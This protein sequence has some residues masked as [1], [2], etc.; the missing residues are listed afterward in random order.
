M[1][2][3][4]KTLWSCM[5]GQYV[6]TNE[7]QAS[8][9]KQAKSVVFVAAAGAM[10]VCGL[11]SAAEFQG[12]ITNQNL[13]TVT[14][15]GSTQATTKLVVGDGKTVQI[16][17]NGS[18]GKLLNRVSSAPA[19]TLD[20]IQHIL[21]PTSDLSHVVI[22]GV[23]GGSNVLNES[24]YTALSE[25]AKGSESS[26]YGTLI[27]KALASFKVPNS[28]PYVGNT[29]IY[30]GD[31]NRESNPLVIGVVGGDLAVKT[32]VKRQGSSLVQM[33]S[34][35][36]F[37]VVGGSAVVDLLNTGGEETSAQLDAAQVRVDGFANA[38]GIVTGGLAVALS[39][40]TTAS[41]VGS[42]HLIFDADPT[43]K[44][45]DLDG[46][47]AGALGGGLSVA[48]G[49][50]F[51]SANA[52]SQTTIELK[53]G[54]IVGLAGGG[55]AVA[56]DIGPEN[57]PGEAPIPQ[58]IH[59]MFFDGAGT[60][61]ALSGDVSVSLGA[62]STTLAVA[63]GGI[64][65]SDAYGS[66][67]AQTN[68]DVKSVSMTLDGNALTAEQ[69][70]QV[71]NAFYELGA[72]AGKVTLEGLQSFLG[73]VS[74]DGV[75]VGTIGGGA[76]VA[77]G[78]FDDPQS[79]SANAQSSVESVLMTVNGG[80][81][82]GVFGGGAAVGWD[83]VSGSQ[84]A[85]GQIQA[86]S[87]V[88]SSTIVVNGGENV[89]VMGG[90]LSYAT[91]T[92]GQNT[93]VAARSVVKT[94]NLLVRNGSV[95]GLVGG[96]LAWNNTN[97]SAVN[98]SVSAETVNILVEGGTVNVINTD[99]FRK[100]GEIGTEFADAFDA[101]GAA[102]VGGGI[103]L[104]EAADATVD[105]VNISVT[106][107]T[108]TGDIVAGGLVGA[109]TD[110]P[111]VSTVRNASVLLS[112]NALFEGRTID[113]STVT[114]EA[115]LFLDGEAVDLAEAT[116]KGFTAL[117]ANGA[118]SIGTV[119]LAGRQNTSFAGLFD[120]AS[121]KNE[122][123]DG[124]QTS[125]VTVESGVLAARESIGSVTYAVSNGVLALGSKAGAQEAARAV[126]PLD[127]SAILLL[128]G[129]V[130]LSGLAVNVGQ[131]SQTASGVTIGQN[132]LLVADAAKNTEVTGTLAAEAG[133]GIYFTGVASDGAQVS[134]DANGLSGFDESKFEVDNIRYQVV[135]NANTFTFSQISDAATLRA[136][137]LDGFSRAV[138]DR[139]ESQTDPAS[140]YV[141]ELLD[142]NNA[143]IGSGS[144][145]HA[146]LNAAFN[147]AAAGGVQT[148]GIESAMIGLD[149]ASKRASLTNEFHDGWSAF[150][151]LTGT[152]ADMGGDRSA[153][154]TRTQ[155]GGI[156]F[157][158][159]YTVSD[160][161]FGVL[162]N[163][164]TGD[165]EGQG[166]NDGVD[167]DVD[168]YGIQAYAAHRFGDFN[169]VG[170][171]G[172]VMTSNDITHRS[173][174][175]VDLDANV[176]TV[177]ARGEWA[178]HL[179]E[180]WRM[181]PY[182]GFNYLH[183]DTDGYTTAKGF[184]VDDDGQDLFNMPVGVA[185]SG[186]IDT[187]SGWSMRPVADIAYVHT[188]GDTDVSS[189]TRVGEA[190]MSTNLDVWTE[191]A[192]RVRFGLEAAKDNMAFGVTLG[193]AAGDNDYRA[194]YGQINAKYV[195]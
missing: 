35:N 190:A 54:T 51:A 132:G 139:I 102:I 184:G 106:G 16:Q 23:T 7:R 88:R 5:R 158:G 182:V 87:E 136:R 159:E 25:L 135:N 150:A 98:A 18:V 70:Q 34:G 195:F 107:G 6:V 157:G 155:L 113:A 71:H 85:E 117:Q 180:N 13:P 181:V 115:A 161:T 94:S 131:T 175:K 20:S 143:A 74:V 67:E 134:F 40:N 149:M 44:A 111:N 10:A 38:G 89:L 121:V 50:S 152:Q 41:N 187:K 26:E 119:D 191:S 138:L 151:E 1:N 130:D 129:E 142:G 162:A 46:V 80:Y 166:D 99:P 116:V 193:G 12:V 105:Q 76:A 100:L 172:W 192:G 65:F 163:I 81:N 82:V 169:L 160:S 29:T 60:A 8:R 179:S 32:S 93:N 170:Q 83:K 69:K 86:A 4:F 31:V 176:Y 84:S 148:A 189:S 97:A 126:E 17:T 141:Q 153:L 47:V 24:L 164:G 122:T 140:L 178:V 104:G 108:V 2:R 168:Y 3:V 90:G 144:Q 183:V 146:Q 19:G 110:D 101:S 177:G 118:A 194:I 45:G 56:A 167:N 125:A 49:G 72:S 156:A 43:A 79:G 145:R 55:A 73:G 11:S 112:S 42:T 123:G 174:D 120:V 171:L 128:A 9:G 63:G 15:N 22:T 33:S 185:F 64:A 188:F 14:V 48:M 92:D 103:A 37:G 36:T 133:N 96:G 95:D 78:S 58:F 75:H 186:R 57:I 30:I 114:E 165:V 61:S 59:G 28:G 137:G 109:S 154:E 173:G 39:G 52:G 91:G 53:N 124:T 127:A 77:R 66:H 68:A 147:L 62:E 21:G 27:E